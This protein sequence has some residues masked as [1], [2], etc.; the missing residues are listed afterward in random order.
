MP[1]SRRRASSARAPGLARLRGSRAWRLEDA[2]PDEGVTYDFK[3]EIERS[4]SVH[5]HAHK[6]VLRVVMGAHGHALGQ[7]GLPSPLAWTV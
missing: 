4:F 3:E 6:R 7:L 1:G 2:W 5:R